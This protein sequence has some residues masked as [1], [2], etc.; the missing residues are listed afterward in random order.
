[1]KGDTRY[2]GLRHTNLGN[3]N[4]NNLAEIELKYVDLG[5]KDISHFLLKSINLRLVNLQ[6]FTPIPIPITAIPERE[7]IQT[8]AYALAEQR[9]Q[10][11]SFTDYK[12]PGSIQDRQHFLKGFGL[13]Q[14]YTSIWSLPDDTTA[15]L[16]E[17]QYVPS[18][19][20]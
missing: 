4:L 8:V 11:L 5:V 14:G 7:F 12:L 1:M 15:D 20:H 19:L 6:Y 13:K 3:W 16:M 2:Y 18:T 17:F 9:L 10:V